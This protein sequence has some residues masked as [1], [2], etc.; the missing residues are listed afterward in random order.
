MM[1]KRF[2]KFFKQASCFGAFTLLFACKHEHTNPVVTVSRGSADFSRFVAIGNSLTAGFADGGL[3]LAG[4]LNSYP[5]IIAGQLKAAGGST[6][7]QPLFTT[8]QANGSGYLKLTGISL[9]GTPVLTE[10]TTNLAIRGTVAV[11][12]AGN[13]T[14]YTKYT[15]SIDNFGVA[16]IKLADI[17]NTNYGNQNGYFERLLPLNAPA[18]TT[19][20]LNFISAK[21]FTFFSNWL[22]NNDALAYA[23]SGGTGDALTSQ[24]MFNR[25]YLQLT[26]RLTANGA[27]GVIATIPDVTA[28][29]YFNTV[30]VALANSYAKN[31]QP[32][33]PGVYITA[34]TDTSSTA[35]Y[36]SRLATSKDLLILTF[37]LTRIGRPV[38]TAA[39][40]PYGLTPSTPID[41]QYVLDQ[42]EVA[43][44]KSYTSAY[45]QTIRNV[46]NNSNLAL[47][48]A[49]TFFNTI[50]ASGQTAGGVTLTSTYLTRNLF[51]VDG[52]HLTPRGY[53]AVANGFISAINAK[54]GSTIK[55][56]DISKYA[57]VQC[58]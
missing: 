14:L 13:V 36:I 23:A 51:S 39:N 45:N 4:Q 47:F 17:N 55:F 41:N 34:R 11:P 21:P 5:N 46:A 2:M 10:V 43:L 26:A 3:Y 54:Y 57:G 49:Y 38:S 35:T 50:N 29:A 40:L 19:A 6:F 52:L 53:A 44:T 58:W 25:L 56:V 32:A 8:D 30:T 42:N 33:L 24:A 37:D 16:G 15:G 28:T 18:N 22:G 1:T 48:D 20:Y 7:N 27:K 12:G 31:V 9:I